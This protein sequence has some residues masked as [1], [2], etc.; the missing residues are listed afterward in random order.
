MDARFGPWVNRQPKL[1][2]EYAR[3]SEL[4][5]FSS[6]CGVG[7]SPDSLVSV[8]DSN[9]H[10]HKQRPEAKTA[11]MATTATDVNG[12]HSIPAPPA[13]SPAID[14]Q[15]V[16]FKVHKVNGHAH[17]I[18]TDGKWGKPEFRSEEMLS[19]HGFASCLNYG[20][21]HLHSSVIKRLAMF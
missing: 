3:S 21:V 20:Q 19:I 4:P 2:R 16:G 1:N 15:A 11:G 17:V 13:P 5:K 12:G 8:S 18:W 14:W 7:N 10:L 9:H 6:E